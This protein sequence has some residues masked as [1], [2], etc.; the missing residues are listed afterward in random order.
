MMQQLGLE[1]CLTS[2]LLLRRPGVQS[3]GHWRPHALE[4]WG[5][6]IEAAAQALLPCSSAQLPSA[7]GML[8]KATRLPPTDARVDRLQ[9]QSCRSAATSNKCIGLQ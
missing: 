7:A 9:S 1:A 3:I 8:P 6:W 4:P 5:C 2:G